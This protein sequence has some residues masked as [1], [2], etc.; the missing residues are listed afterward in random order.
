[1]DEETIYEAGLGGLLH[2]T[3][4][5]LVP[6]AILNKQGRLTDEEFDVIKRH[7]RDGP[8][9][10]VRP[11]GLDCCLRAME[12]L[13][14]HDAKRDDAL[15]KSRLSRNADAARALRATYALNGNE[16]ASRVDFPST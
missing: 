8:V 10:D 3:G 12:G 16:R 13:A 11:S 1:M 7:P 5:A 2:D 14:L 6:D 4:K 9:T 15:G